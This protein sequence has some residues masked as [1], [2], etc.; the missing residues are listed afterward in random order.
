MASGLPI[1]GDFTTSYN[2]FTF[3]PEDTLTTSLRIT[4]VPTT[5]RRSIAYNAITV[6]LRTII[7][8]QPTGSTVLQARQK[9][10]KQG[11]VFVYG[12]RGVG[13]LTVNTGK[14]RDVMY[15]P[16]PKVLSLQPLGYRNACRLDWEVTIHIPECAD[17]KYVLAA[18]DLSFTVTHRPQ[19]DGRVHLVYSGQLVI[20]NN[21]F[22]PTSTVSFDNPDL[23]RSR[24]ATALPF[25]FQREWGDWTIDPSRT[26]LS[27][28]WTDKEFGRN[29]Y[30]PGIVAAKASHVVQ[31]GKDCAMVK[32]VASLSAD[33]TL[34]AGQDPKIAWKHFFEVL[35]K[36]RVRDNAVKYGNVNYIPAGVTVREPDIYGEETTVGIDMAYMISNT[37]LRQI[38]EHSGLWKPTGQDWKLWEQSLRLTALNPYG[39]SQVVFNIETDPIINLC[40]SPVAVAVKGVANTKTLRGAEL[41]GG[42]LFDPPK[43]A[44]SWLQYKNF[45]KAEGSSGIITS[46]PLAD[47]VPPKEFE[48]RGGAFPGAAGGVK[49]KDTAPI[50]PKGVT[51]R[52]AAAN[53]GFFNPPTK[54]GMAVAAGAA[55]TGRI[56]SDVTPTQDVRFTRRTNSTA[57]VY[58]TGWALRAGYAIPCPSL[59]SINGVPCVNVSR[60]DRGE[61]FTTGIVRNDGVPIVGAKW[62]LRYELPYLPP[63][64]LPVMPDPLANSGV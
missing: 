21:R 29:V 63:G 18:M 52:Q 54:K 36:Q 33:Y 20:P 37:T 59:T 40:R 7:S 3:P 6:G 1:P 39:Y 56:E 31:S 57:V 5:D 46:Q 14:V 11:G 45:L 47:S 2:G 53:P 10:T 35:F 44:N 60:K 42:Q 8:G 12:G 48:L 34:A 9:L 58:M 28:A 17:A 41:R 32:W 62:N 38:L 13:A 26:T 51:P 50:L 19:R 30:P 24:I 22:Q 15:G 23:Y 43:P 61:E 49:A 55:A 25:G 27:F 16:V 64:E 4:P